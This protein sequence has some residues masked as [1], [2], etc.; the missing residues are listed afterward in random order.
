[1][2][3]DTFHRWVEPMGVVLMLLVALVLGLLV[4]RRHGR[5]EQRRLARSE[6]KHP[7][8]APGR[9]VSALVTA[10]LAVLVFVRLARE[11]TLGRLQSFDRT[12]ALAVHSLDGAIMNP[13]MRLATFIGSPVVVLPLVCAVLAAALRRRDHRGALVLLLVALMTEGLNVALK[14]TFER[15]RPTLF[16]E[17]AA[18]HSYSFPSG[19][20]MAA[21]AIYGMMGVVIARLSPRHH[22]LLLV[23]LP[24]LV[25]AIGLSRI[26]LGVHWPTDV[27][28]GFAAGSFL[29]LAGTIALDGVPTA[30]EA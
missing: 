12:V 18:L 25:F 11:V 26:F 29:L 4:V 27:L 7:F 23:T 30:N 10:G 22:R 14:G 1:M 19:H 28:A 5:G 13:A 20:A 6:R 9:S 21:A 17:V 8:A 2:A 3:P 15:E 16:Q 24:I